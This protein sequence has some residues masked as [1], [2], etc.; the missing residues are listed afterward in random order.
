MNIFTSLLQRLGSQKAA[1]N[2]YP[3]T[4]LPMDGGSDGIG[5][6][7]LLEANKEWVFIAVDKI[8]TSVA[9]IRFK[10]MRYQRSGDDQEVFEGPLTTFLESPAANFTP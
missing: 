9:G 8:A 4:W 6:A 10:V 1:T 5:T 2:D 7:N 3:G